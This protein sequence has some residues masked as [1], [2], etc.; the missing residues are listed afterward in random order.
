MSPRRLMLSRL[1]DEETENREISFRSC[2]QETREAHPDKYG[3]PE[4]P[5]NV[6]C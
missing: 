2:Q 4:E 3:P 1:V 6:A 5:T